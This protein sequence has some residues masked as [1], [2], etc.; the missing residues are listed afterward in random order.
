MQ[1]AVFGE[2]EGHSRHRLDRVERAI[3]N[4]HVTDLWPVRSTDLWA[5]I[6]V[7]VES[8]VNNF[9]VRLNAI[10]HGG[11]EQVQLLQLPDRM[12][13]LRQDTEVITL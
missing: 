10:K 13:Q 5:T 6:E 8:E 11:C 12:G 3:L 7:E 1:Q 9:S 2:V 4:S